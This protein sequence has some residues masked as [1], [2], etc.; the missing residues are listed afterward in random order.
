M[1]DGLLR[2]ERE[3]IKEVEQERDSTGRGQESPLKT[4]YI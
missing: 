2:R 4:T 3:W 1:N